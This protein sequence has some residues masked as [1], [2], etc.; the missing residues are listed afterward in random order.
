[1]VI[2]LYLSRVQAE[3]K[4]VKIEIPKKIW[5]FRFDF[6]KVK[7]ARIGSA[8]KSNFLSFYHTIAFII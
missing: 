6:K 3:K 5:I 7:P 1:M 4:I 2:P 8:I